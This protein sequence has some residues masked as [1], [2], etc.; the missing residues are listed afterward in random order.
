[1]NWQEGGRFCVAEPDLGLLLV[2]SAGLMSAADFEAA[3]VGGQT[4]QLSGDAAAMYRGYS[5]PYRGLP[6]EGYNGMRRFPLSIPVDNYHNGNGAG[7]T[8]HYR[9]LLGWDKGCHFIWGCLDNVF[10]EDWGRAWAE[11]MRARF[12][13]LGDAGHFP[14]NTHGPHLVELIL[15]GKS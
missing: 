15:D 7:Q 9:T 4:P 8:L 6:D 5:A 1:M 10:T 14:Q 2:M 12:D 13:A 3:F 11:R